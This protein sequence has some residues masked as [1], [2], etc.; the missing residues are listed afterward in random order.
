MSRSTAAAV[1]VALVCVS[2]GLAGCGGQTAAPPSPAQV[3]HTRLAAMVS[4]RWLTLDGTVSMEGV[5]YPVTF[6]ENDQAGANGSVTV[7]RKSVAVTWTGGKL[8]LKNA[9]YFDAQQVYTGNRWTLVQSDKLAALVGALVDRKALVSALTAVAGPNVR[10]RP[11]PTTQG[12]ATILLG[13]D[14]L[15]ATVPAGGGTPLRLAT[16]LDQK[17]SD[18]LADLRLN[19]AA[20]S[21][22]LPVTPPPTFVELA[23]RNSLPAQFEEDS[24]ASNPFHW[25]SCDARGCTLNDQFR[26]QGGRLGTASV[27]FEVDSGGKTVGTCNV[28]IPATD[29][30]GTVRAGCR[31]NFDNSLQVQARANITNPV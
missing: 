1:A 21:A 29:N 26:N 16:A 5:S 19:V 3:L 18:G 2:L 12:V 27:T 31:A 24:P 14:T 10:Q 23:N 17:L 7:A 6:N 25:D 11:G 9:D 22:P 20:S 15:T 28:E 13:S 30:G 8:F 4:A